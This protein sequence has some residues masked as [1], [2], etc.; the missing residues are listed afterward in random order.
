MTTYS[1][2]Q[3]TKPNSKLALV[4][5]KHPPKTDIPTTV[6]QALQDPNWRPPMSEEFDAQIRNGTWDLVPPDPSQ[7]LVGVRWV[8]MIKELSDGSVD[9]YKARL[10]AKGFHQRQGLDY[11]ETFSHVI[12]STTIR[13]VLGVAVTKEWYIRQLDINNAFLQ[14][15]LDEEVYVAQPPSFGIWT[16]RS[17]F[18]IK[19][20]FIRSQTSSVCVVPRTQNLH[21][22]RRF[23]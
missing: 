11:S 9:K 5:I 1:K 20:S 23:C 14:G 12:K 3:I 18:S 2:N 8:F 16:D 6:S 7:N 19:E 13:I 22:I 17:I 15:T 21:L 10:V 4:T